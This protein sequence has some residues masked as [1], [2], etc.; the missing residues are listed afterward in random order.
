[1]INPD[2]ENLRLLSIS[3]YVVGGLTAV[4]ACFPLIHLSI[5]L[6]LV[7]SSGPFGHMNMHGGQPPPAFFGWIFV[8]IGAILFVMGQSLAICMILSGRFISQRKKYTFAFVVAC[9]ECLMM[10]FGTILGIFTIITLSRDSVK[11]IFNGTAAA[12]P[13][14]PR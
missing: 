9:L 10:P 3:H 14:M 5:G 2:E 6:M 11:A 1:M 4:F 12:P 8:A 7:T 13:P